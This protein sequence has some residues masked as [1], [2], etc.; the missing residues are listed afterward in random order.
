MGT[1][2][3]KIISDLEDNL[4]KYSPD[5]VITMM[6]INDDVIYMLYDEAVSTSKIMLFFKSFKTSD[7]EP[8]SVFISTKAVG[9]SN[10]LII[11]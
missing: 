4:N 8:I 3:E 7:S 2:T 6:G 1:T 9:I 5:M 11:D 10:P